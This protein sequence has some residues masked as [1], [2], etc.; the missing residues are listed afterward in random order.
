[1]KAESCLKDV[2]N[3]EKVRILIK[4]ENDKFYYLG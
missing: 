1:L 3:N 2:I 4:D